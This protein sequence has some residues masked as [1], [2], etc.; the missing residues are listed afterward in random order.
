MPVV[1]PG[2]HTGCSGGQLKG[3]GHPMGVQANENTFWKKRKTQNSR[4]LFSRKGP[5]YST[6]MIIWECKRHPMHRILILK[7]RKT[8]TQKKETMWS[9]SIIN[10]HFIFVYQFYTFQMAPK[11]S[12]HLILSAKPDC[13]P[14]SKL[15]LLSDPR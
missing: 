11:L 4:I 8:E 13:S 12:S 14:G 5:L 9:V 10:S 2:R 7:T 15:N 6:K 1:P 3:E